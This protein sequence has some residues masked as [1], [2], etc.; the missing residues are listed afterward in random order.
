MYRR[1]IN[2]VNPL[3]TKGDLSN[4]FSDLIKSLWTNNWAVYAREFKQAFGKHNERFRG[5]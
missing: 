2:P 1:Q 3:G 5:S 4:A